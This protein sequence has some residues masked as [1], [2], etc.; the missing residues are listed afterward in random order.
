ME[1]VSQLASRDICLQTTNM[2][3]TKLTKSAG[4]L[5]NKVGVALTFY[6]K[7]QDNGYLLKE[8]GGKLIIYSIDPNNKITW[9][10]LTR[11]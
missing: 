7:K 8:D 2:T 4:V 6:L 10:K 1:I 9:K 5:W 11:P 3:W